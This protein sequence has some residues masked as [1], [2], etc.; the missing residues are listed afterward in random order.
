[1]AEWE[2][3]LWVVAAM[4]ASRAA[5]VYGLTPLAGMTPGAPVVDRKFQTVIFW[6]GLRGAVALAIVLSLP[7]FPNADRFVT[8]VTGAV[9][10]TLL[11]QG[12]TVEG[13]IHALGLD[14]PPLA[15]RFARLEARIAALTH[16][17]RRAP[18]LV[19]SGF[20]SAS[21]G[22]RLVDEV[23]ADLAALADE[24]ARL[25]ADELTP[26]AERRLLVLFGLS[27]EKSFA[28][29][30]FA[31]GHLTEEAYHELA[32]NLDVQ[33]D[34]VRHGAEAATVDYHHL[35]RRRLAKWLV[36]TMDRIAPLA[37]W[38]QRAHRRRIAQDYE[39]AWARRHGALRVM[40][41]L[42]TYAADRAFDATMV[43][44]IRGRYEAWGKRAAA[45]LDE[46]AA[47]TPAFVAA[48]QERLGRRLMALAEEE[49]VVEQDRRGALPHGV[50]EEAE[51]EIRHR[52]RRLRG[53][54]TTA[55]SV[56]PDEL[57][58]K[59]RW[60]AEVDPGE[61]AVLT[62]SMRERAFAERETVIRQGEKGEALYLIVRG[63][64]RV[65]RLDD[66]GTDIALAT[67]MAGDFFGEH[68]LL[69]DEPR[70][71]TV[72]AVTPCALYELR[73]ADVHTLMAEHPTIR[74]A[75]ED[76]EARRG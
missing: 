54:E 10:F 4:L 29:E 17:R 18:E 5:V 3:L 27:E 60:F 72:T 41:E 40:D 19:D 39:A 21:V 20:F 46:Y 55:L 68:A 58:R 36:A 22:A 12:L 51:R 45:I 47:E 42:D 7:T 67:L 57:L 53:V 44:A 52:L 69:S 26:D 31:K 23:D 66:A 6:G 56:T 65:S 13:L 14:V 59:I 49:T 28:R 30:L 48:M 62:A 25:R 61:F 24:L 15:D 34:A 50:A 32:L 11:V 2:G 64:A 1:M 16:A 74:A 38:A 70:N 75:I 33:I 8:L 43:A 9:L 73:R 76:A 71:A 37:E 63:V 35:R